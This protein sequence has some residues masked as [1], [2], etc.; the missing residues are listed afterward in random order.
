MT[1][2]L[3]TAE[4]KGTGESGA[5][6]ERLRARRRDNPRAVE[7]G[8][9]TH[10]VDELC[11]EAADTLTRLEAALAQREAEV[12][13]LREALEPFI[14][15]ARVNDVEERAGNIEIPVSDLRRLLAL[16]TQGSKAG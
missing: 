11:V 2:A 5:L 16:S 3:P 15:H 6:V 14:E 8:Q 4:P 13:W 12:A 10:I 7:F 9:P 1:A